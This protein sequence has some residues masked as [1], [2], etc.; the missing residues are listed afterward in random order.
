[1]VDLGVVVGVGFD[2]IGVVEAGPEVELEEPSAAEE[3]VDARGAAEGAVAR[4]E[5]TAL[6]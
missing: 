6:A 1:V 2:D 4:Q 3:M 5:Q